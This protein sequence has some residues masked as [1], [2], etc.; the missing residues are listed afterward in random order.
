MEEFNTR[1]KK[2]FENM[3]T[4]PRVVEMMIGGAKDDKDKF[5]TLEVITAPTNELEL[6]IAELLFSH[7]RDVISLFDKL[8]S[9]EILPVPLENNE[10]VKFEI[11][12]V[13]LMK[14]GGDIE[15]I[16]RKYDRPEEAAKLMYDSIALTP[17]EEEVLKYIGIWTGFDVYNEFDYIQ[18][19]SLLDQSSEIL[20]DYN[21]DMIIAGIDDMTEERLS[22]IKKYTN[23]FHRLC[24]E[25]RTVENDKI[26]IFK[27]LKFKRKN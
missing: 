2:Y 17:D 26:D 14:N 10:M 13:N 23:E 25:G 22:D 8:M 1:R 12:M 21:Q 4:Y 24:E 20:D 9:K 5:R 6:E 7:T 3:R 11:K 19:V 15:T 27:L 18:L 16:T